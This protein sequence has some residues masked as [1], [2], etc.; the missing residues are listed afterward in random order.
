MSSPF[1]HALAL[2]D[3]Y[4]T[5]SASERAKALADL[6]RS[7]PDTHDALR[8]L[9]ASD[10]ALKERPDDR[11]VLDSVPP[12]VLARHDGNA[13]ERLGSDRR[14]GSRLGPWRIIGVLGRGGMGTV[15]EAHRD[16]GHYQQRVA[17]KCIRTELSSAVV[18]DSFRTERKILA[19]LDHPNIAMLFDGGIDDDGA[20]W[21]AMRY[22]EGAPIDEWCDQQR[23]SLRRRVELLVDA[24]TA[25]AYAHQRMVLHQDIKPSNLLVTA[26]GQLQLLDFGLA[27]S[28]ASMEPTPRIAVSL[29]YTAPE[30][31]AGAPPSISMDVWSLGMVM[32][33]LL[34]G[35]VPSTVPLG[36]A[37]S[38][39]AT[40]MAPVPMSE[41]A[42]NAP[43]AVAH[44]RG[45]PDPMALSRR[46]T[47]DLDAIAARCTAW[48]PD[49]RYASIEAVRDDLGRWLTSLPVEAR[50]GGAIYR[51]SRFVHRFPVTTA[52]VAA[53]LLIAATGVSFAA[54]N[55][56]RASEEAES[57]TMLAHVF[58]QT[59]G[60][61]TLSGLGSMPMSSN[62]LLDDTERRVRAL[63]LQD[64][65]H[66]LARGLSMLARN[67][68]AVGNYAHATTLAEEAAALRS[69]DAASVAATQAT[70]A[71]LLN[72]RGRHADAL[73]VAQQALASP[74][75]IPDPSHRLQLMAEAARSHWNLAEHGPAQEMLG[76]AL[77]LAA[78]AGDT[79]SQAELLTLRG[80]WN[81]RLF[82]FA[83]ADNDLRHAIALAMPGAPL[84]ANEA[85]LIAAQS[86]LEQER[87]EEARKLIEQLHADYLG[88]LG[89]SHPLTGIAWGALANV[90]CHTSLLKECEASLR[91][92]D[93]IILDR[94]GEQHPEYANVLR[95]HSTLS[96]FIGDPA[97]KNIDYLRRS[98]AIYSAFYPPN[99][100]SVQRARRILGRRLLL[101]NAGLSPRERERN[102]NESIALYE[103]VIQHADGV[104][105][106]HPQI[107]ITLGN[108]LAQ[109]GAPG[110]LARA[111][112]L[113]EAN[114]ETIGRFPAGS[115]TGFLNEYM[116]A[117]LHVMAGDLATADALL[118]PL[119]AALAGRQ[120]STNNRSILGSAF[121][122]RATIAQAR[123]DPKQART[124]LVRAY[125]HAL[126]AYGPGGATT[127]AAEAWLEEIDHD[128]R[129]QPPNE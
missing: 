51:A 1:A 65:P 46:L 81:L 115:Y 40:G 72:L 87:A 71:S 14:L 42:R 4:V 32:Y 64:H 56:R 83:R 78:R 120:T 89:E 39:P 49:L 79:R 109:R 12:V 127:R 113:I 57:R 90:Q 2:F 66:V 116:L 6:Q 111:R 94:Y 31:I 98:E 16:D 48:R 76:D 52:L 3:D 34:C 29:G 96:S 128:G 114:R 103:S 17:L 9:L 105:P 41:L 112:R 77:A 106:L 91:Q 118:E 122:L 55:A 60:M 69:D 124:W 61:A 101:A 28:L 104:V 36:L 37:V 108:A 23:S 70:L 97:A 54:W 8:A 85:R 62:A 67:Y 5:M 125:D 44:R 45:L 18:V 47:G 58:E 86:L 68:A 43:S 19:G 100:E 88:R 53:T 59:L 119:V 102:R 7:A 11:H 33:R 63:S 74:A 75:G 38:V 25:L 26:Q 24:C 117:R 95:I 84:V 15:Y 21:F 121:V 126:A 20:P 10:D 92:A 35:I 27:A 99:H 13:V 30:A 82:H 50:K 73:R 93:H 110:D 22:V 80:Y 107:N 123:G 129:F